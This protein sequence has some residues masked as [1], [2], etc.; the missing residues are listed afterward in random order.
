M[1]WNEKAYEIPMATI[2]N[3][4]GNNQI[5]TASGSGVETPIA[6]YAARALN[7]FIDGTN[8]TIE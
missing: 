2:Y 4:G 1:N 3:F 8:T 6:D 7:A 5:L